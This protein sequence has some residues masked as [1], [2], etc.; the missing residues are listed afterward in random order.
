MAQ[1]R[2]HQ[3]PITSVEWSPHDST[4]LGIK[5]VQN[6]IKPNTVFMASGEDDQTTIWDLALEEDEPTGNNGEEE[7]TNEDEEMAGE[8]GGG[9]QKKQQLPPQLLFI[10]MGQ[11]GLNLK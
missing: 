5:S 8:E 3:K 10:H 4:G 1:F 7:A 9:H 11:K 2:H 6:Q